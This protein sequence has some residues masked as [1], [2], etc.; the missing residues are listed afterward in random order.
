MQKSLWML[1]ITSCVINLIG[2]AVDFIFT[3]F[4]AQGR[5]MAC[6]VITNESLAGECRC[7]GCDCSAFP[8]LIARENLCQPAVSLLYCTTTHMHTWYTPR[9]C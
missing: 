5:A 7:T 4:C 6:Q 8:G 3:S 1:Y 2:I 9:A